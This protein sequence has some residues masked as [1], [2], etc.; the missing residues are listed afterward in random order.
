MKIKEIDF[1]K[2]KYT[3]ICVIT[4]HGDEFFPA[5]AEDAVINVL[6]EREVQ[7]EGISVD[8]D[9]I[10]LTVPTVKKNEDNA[11]E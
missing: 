7:A 4:D 8:E 9:G 6:G 1:S 5:G 10:W 3:R 11:A 2:Y